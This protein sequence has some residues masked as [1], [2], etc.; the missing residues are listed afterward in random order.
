MTLQTQEGDL[1]ADDLPALAHGCNCSGVMGAG[2]AKQFK[3]R[4]PAMFEAY[5]ERCRA[6][7]FELGD[8]FLWRAE[9]GPVIYNLATQS[10]PGPHAN[11]SAIRHSIE[12]VLRPA[13]QAKI[14][15]IG[16]PRLGAGHGGLEL[17]DVHGVL[18]DVAF[19][20]DVILTVY[21]L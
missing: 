12:R 7:D 1:F 14:E 2:I 16:I 15:Q 18:E 5:R 4:W 9:K 10:R 17:D 11:L 6:G 8:V 19:N 20:S 21:Q 13:E 3:H